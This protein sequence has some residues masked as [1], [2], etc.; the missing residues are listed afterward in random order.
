MCGHS[1]P[2]AQSDHKQLLYPQTVKSEHFQVGQVRH[3]IFHI[4]FR[5]IFYNRI[6]SFFCCSY[7]FELLWDTQS[8]VL[9]AMPREILDG[10]LVSSLLC[11]YTGDSDWCS[12]CIPPM[13]TFCQLGLTFG[14]FSFLVSFSTAQSYG[15]LP[16]LE[17]ASLPALQ[18]QQ[19]HLQWDC[20]REW[21]ATACA[22]SCQL[23]ATIP[24]MDM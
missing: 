23:P 7:K 12:V 24:Y 14:Y 22:R 2:C 21:L 17:L 13:T 9:A 18:M 1:F 20:Q 3:F 4:G 8:W 5:F 15:R 19:Q 6:P 11:K 10:N 16:P